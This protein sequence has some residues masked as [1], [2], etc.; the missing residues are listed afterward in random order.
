MMNV[1]QADSLKLP[2]HHRKVVAGIK[3]D[4]TLPFS[5][6]ASKIVPAL[7]WNPPIVSHS[8]ISWLVGL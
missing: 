7:N 2:D 3:T 4:G 1:E 6:S 5:F 8:R